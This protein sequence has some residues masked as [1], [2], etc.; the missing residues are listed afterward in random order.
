MAE[1]ELIHKPGVLQSPEQL[2]DGASSGQVQ[3]AFFIEF[4]RQLIRHTTSGDA[5]WLALNSAMHKTGA[6]KEDKRQLAAFLKR[7]HDQ[8]IFPEGMW[9]ALED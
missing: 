1:K 5:I 7:E 9:V 6:T 4:V 3:A 2:E 8:N